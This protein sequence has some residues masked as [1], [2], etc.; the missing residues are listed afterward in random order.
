MKVFKLTN[1]R[2]ILSNLINERETFNNERFK[3]ISK[4]MNGKI[5]PKYASKSVLTGF[6]THIMWLK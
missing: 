1:C 3:S 5:N 6:D 2:V 4:N